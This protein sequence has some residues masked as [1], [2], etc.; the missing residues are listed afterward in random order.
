MGAKAT[1]YLLPLPMADE[2]RALSARTHVPQ[3]RYLYGAI[4]AMLSRWVDSEG[5]PTWPTLPDGPSVSVVFR[6]PE[7]HLTDLETLAARTRVKRSEW[8][9]L[10]VHDML[11]AES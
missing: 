11:K 2:L 5:L 4:N 8:V 10:A 7:E 9:R 6:L 3:A 1:H